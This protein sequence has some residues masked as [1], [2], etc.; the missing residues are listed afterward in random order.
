MLFYQ[1]TDQ[2]TIPAGGPSARH[3]AEI[4]AAAMR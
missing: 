4:A 2:F 1:F 3:N